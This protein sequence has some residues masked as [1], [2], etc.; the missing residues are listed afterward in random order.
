M[1]SPAQDQ[2]PEIPYKHPGKDESGKTDAPMSEIGNE[3]LKREAAEEK[4]KQPS[5]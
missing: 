5:K 1:K 4:E 2:Q 3:T